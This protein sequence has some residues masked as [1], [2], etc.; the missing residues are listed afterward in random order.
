MK[1]LLFPLFSFGA[2]FS[3]C[4]PS[5][6]LK[7]AEANL[8]TLSTYEKELANSSTKFALDLF[9]Q[10]N[11]PEEPNQFYSPYSIHQALSMTMNGNE[12]EVLQEFVDLLRY[13]G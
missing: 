2:L 4:V 7:P 13:E 1:K 6:E 11:D 10:L 8:R 9:A 5:E 3:A 12:G